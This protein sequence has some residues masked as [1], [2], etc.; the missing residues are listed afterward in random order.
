MIILRKHFSEKKDNTVRDLSLIGN[1]GILGTGA[2][3]LANTLKMNDKIKNTLTDQELKNLGIEIMEPEQM[4]GIPRIDKKTLLRRERDSRNKKI[5]LAG[6]GLTAAAGLAYGGKKLYDKKKKKKRNAAMI[7][8]LKRKIFGLRSE[9]E[10][11]IDLG[12]GLTLEKD[13]LNKFAEWLGK[14]IKPIG[15]GQEKLLDYII[16]LNGEKV[17]VIYLSEQNPETL[18]I[19]W[20]NVVTKYRG[21]GYATK[22]LLSIIKLA[23]SRN[24]KKLVLEAIEDSQDA[25]HIYKKL[26]FRIIKEYPRDGLLLMELGL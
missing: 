12:G 4:D 23:K 25:V 19:S 5:A 7:I 13:P 6:L 1:A 16:K 24:Y 14:L 11:I 26:G 10:N 2:G 17:G 22:A 20:I 21:N 15:R 8:K 9:S 3:V 18:E